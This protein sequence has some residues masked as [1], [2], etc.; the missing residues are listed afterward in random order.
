MVLVTRLGVPAIRV[1]GLTIL[2]ATIFTS[3]NLY[4]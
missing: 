2:S 4:I 1:I 3:Y